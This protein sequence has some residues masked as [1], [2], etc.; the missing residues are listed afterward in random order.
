MKLIIDLKKIYNNIEFIFY[1]GK[2]AEYDFS[3]FKD[4]MNRGIGDYTKFLIPQIVNNTNKIIILDSADI[5]AKKDLSEIYFFDI[6][7]NYF[8]FALDISAGRFSKYFIFA[9]NKFYSNIGV[10]LVNVRMFKKDNLYMAGYFARLAYANM[11]CPTQ[12]MFFMISRYR[13]KFFPLIYNCPQFLNDDNEK[14]INNKE[15][16]LIDEFLELQKNSP[17]RYTKQEIIESENN[18][19]VTH[20]FTTKILKNKASKKNGKLWINYVKLANVYEILKKKFPETF[21]YYEE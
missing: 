3:T 11:P 8:A 20:L 14:H 13:F 18:E 9:R 21:K 15:Y 1:N 7:D 17:F 5:I 12:E 10:T 6:D 4:G 19:V 16:P 2:Q